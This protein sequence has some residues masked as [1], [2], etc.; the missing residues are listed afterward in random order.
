MCILSFMPWNDGSS[1]GLKKRN[2]ILC[3]EKGTVNVEITEKN[4]IS[5]ERRRGE[6]N[7]QPTCIRLII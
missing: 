1:Y 6:I 3:R 5:R 4:R 2:S 7:Y